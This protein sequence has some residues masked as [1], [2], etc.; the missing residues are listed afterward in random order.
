MKKEKERQR[1][2]KL[3]EKQKSKIDKVEA[4][5]I[6]QQVKRSSSSN[7]VNSMKHGQSKESANQMK[8]TDQYPD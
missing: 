1:T 3:Q 4:K 7:M 5:L 6:V 2:I 8:N